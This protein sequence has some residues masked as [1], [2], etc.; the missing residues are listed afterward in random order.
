MRWKGIIFLVVLAIIVF[1][2]S[3][4]FTDRWLEN[5][6]EELGSPI[7]GAKVE[8]DNLDFSIIGLHLRWD[9]LQ[10][11]DSKDTWTNLLETGKC[12]LDLRFLPLLSA[13]VIVDNMQISGVQSG[14]KRATD[15][16]IIKAVEKEE[17]PGFIGKTMQKLQDQV[18]QAPA[19]NLDQ[20][21]RKVNVDSVIKLLKLQAP[22]KIDSLQ[23]GLQQNYAHWDSLIEK[24]N[25]E[26]DIQ[27]LEAKIKSVQPAEIKT[28][29]DLQAALV[30]V[31]QIR[32]S[33]DSLQKFVTTSKS[34]L[35]NDIK[36]AQ[37]QVAQVDDWIKGDF[38]RAMEMAKLPDL[39][40]QNI[41]KMLFGKK[42][43]SQV[44]GYLGMAAKARYY[45]SKLSSDK[46]KKEKPPR[47]KGQ[48]I[49]FSQKTAQPKFWI[50]KIELS[51][52]TPQQLQMS[53]TVTDI[54]SD[55]R[56]IGKT[57]NISL[58]GSRSDGAALSFSGILNYLH[59]A[60][61]EKFTLNANAMPLANVK[62]S[63]TQLLPQKIEKG[64]GF[65]ETSLE[66]G[67]ESLLAKIS[68]TAKDLSFEFQQEDASL[69]KLEKAMRGVVQSASTIDFVAAIESKG[70]DTRFSLNSNLDDLFAKQLRS[71]LSAEV[72][73]ARKKIQNY[74]DGQV[75]SKRERLQKLVQEK[76]A[77]LEGQLSK[78]SA[79]L[80]NQMKAVDDKRKAIE[81]RIEEEKSGKAKK[82]EEEAKKKL[83]KIF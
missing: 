72:D 78:Y 41:G 2:L 67:E 74:V 63:D 5:R 22:A 14:T 46:P 4:I 45:A 54:V 39:S 83:K 71:M 42:V 73:A 69:S 19:W 77:Y 47:L 65:L 59:E 33:T 24:T 61:S 13:D 76:Q 37:G 8:F 75:Q 44:N 28:L 40:A 49:L 56:T 11:A 16:K 21:T 30:T 53:G 82:V 17:A 29:A 64:K 58:E 79:A 23:N 32:G 70:E 27:D 36:S 81:Q 1:A 25:F 18:S 34:D 62:L 9:R 51:G 7:A 12:E 43:V 80:Q 68:F 55:Q 20:Y 10:V 31:N 66:L 6:L 35:Q 3:L 50:K 38:Q 60:P 48:D 26:K 52:Q 57:T 15:G